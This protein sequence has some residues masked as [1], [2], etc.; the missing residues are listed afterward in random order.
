MSSGKETPSLP[1]TMVYLT[2][3]RGEIFGVLGPNGSGK[4]TLIRLVSTLLLPDEPTTGLDPHSK[5]DV[6]AFVQRVRTEHDATVLLTTHDMNEAARLCDRIAIIAV[7][8]VISHRVERYAKRSEPDRTPQA[9][10]LTALLLDL[11]LHLQARVLVEHRR[12]LPTDGARQHKGYHRLPRRM[13]IRSQWQY[14]D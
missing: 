8:L 14:H 3:F 5:C 2:V 4:S 1:F 9:Q 10:R 12:C 11:W 13:H 7:G 6:Q